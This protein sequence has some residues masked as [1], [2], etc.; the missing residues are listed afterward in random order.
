M[1]SCNKISAGVWSFAD[2]IT[3]ATGWS[4]HGIAFI[5]GAFG[6]LALAPINITPAMACPM[7]AAVWLIDGS[8]QQ[9]SSSTTASLLASFKVGWWLGFG[10]FLA[11][12]WWLGAALLVEADQFAWALPLAVLGLPAGLA[13]FT[14]IG[15]S[16]AHLLWS[17]TPWRVFALSTGFSGAEWL[18]GKILSGF[19]WN[20]VGMALAGSDSLAQTSAV[21][22]LHGLNLIA[23]LIFA[24]PAILADRVSLRQAS[25]FIMPIIVLALL[26]MMGVFGAVRL[27]GHETTYLDGAKLRLMQP[28]LPQDAKFQPENGLEILEHYLALSLTPP[29]HEPASSSQIT[30]IIW[31]ESA[32]PFILFQQPVA[33][34]LIAEKLNKKILIT[35]AA[36]AQGDAFLQKQK[37][38]NAIEVVAGDKLVSFFDKIHLVPFG[39]YLPL[40]NMLSPLGVSHLVPGVWDRGDAQRLLAVP[41]LPLAAPLI[42]YEAVFSGEVV[43]KK[44]QAP[45]PGWLLNVTND[46]WFGDTIGPYQHFAQARLRAIEEGLPLVRV[47]NTGVSAV[48]DPYGRVLQALPVGKEG[49]IDSPLPGV[50]APTIFSRLGDRVFLGLWLVSALIAL[51]SHMASKVRI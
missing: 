40:E 9:H 46:G 3:L 15:F 2:N 13:L 45:R 22:G 11:S 49:V 36:R 43:E 6:T 16:F 24:T 37:I 42:C 10:Y 50:A 38:Y 28:N 21:V 8:R 17:A 25:R 12:L 33:L 29:S 44:P 48:V 5:S 34:S 7:I 51:W 23:I 30:H 47:A 32:F 14:A 35:G 18:R 4:R 19:P 26:F 41:G 31:P 27:N 20:D 39:E 1:P